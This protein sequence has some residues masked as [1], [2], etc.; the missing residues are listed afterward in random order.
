VSKLTLFETVII[1]PMLSIEQINLDTQYSKAKAGFEGCITNPENEYLNE[2]ID[3]P[4]SE[5]VAKKESVKITFSGSE[6]SH[7]IVE[8]L[9]LLF[10]PNDEKIGYYCL[11]EDESGKVVDD[12]LVFE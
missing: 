12:Y 8:T 9:L 11:H 2:E 5:I 4:I 6:K 10:T 1:I 3:I 7:Y